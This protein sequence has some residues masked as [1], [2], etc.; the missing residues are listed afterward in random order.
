MK[1]LLQTIIFLGCYGALHAQC[2]APA[3]QIELHANNIQ[4]RILNGGDLFSDFNKGQFIPNPTPGVISPST[5]YTAG[6]WMGGVDPGGNLKIAAVDYRGTGKTDYSA[7]PLSLEGTTDDITCYNWDR[8]F[9]VTGSEIASFLNALPLTTGQAVAQFPAVMG[10]PARGNST[11]AGIWGFD[12]P[13]TTQS[14]APFVDANGDGFYTPLAGDYPAVELRGMLPFVPA[15]IIWCV[16]NDQKGGANHP[17]TNGNP[18]QME[19]QLTTWAFNCPD[20]PVLNNTIFTSH[21]LINRSSENLDSFFVG[22]WVDFDLGCHMD[23]YVGCDPNRNTMYVYNQDAQDGN[24]GITCS[25]TPTF[26]TNPPVQSVTFLG[27]NSIQEN[28]LHSFVAYGIGGSITDDPTAPVEYYSNLTGH[29]LG[30]TPMTYGGTGSGGST[31]TK[32]LFPDDPANPNGWSMCTNNSAAG[33]RRVIGNRSVGLLQPGQVSELNT[34]W[35]VHF[36]TPPPCNLGNTLSEVD[37]LHQKHNNGYAGLCSSVSKT[38]LAP[39]DN[40]ELFPNPTA[41]DATLRYGAIKVEEIRVFDAAGKLVQL[42]QNV[43]PGET[44]LKTSQLPVGVYTLQV[45]T[46]EGI[47]AKK[48][49]LVR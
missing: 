32:H 46:A 11:F 25:G 38:T 14:L 23:D 26:T 28:N 12:L 33:D 19:V 44:M 49:T 1:K 22:L 9:R 17:V 45:L 5:I 48:L 16:F 37:V 2:P 40:V 10:W 3:S 15:E 34:A 47:L 13:F 39:A 7:G 8:H 4:A 18:I 6:L 42:L 31:P 41:A 43:E 29:W 36:N 20:E 35:T 30:G 24:P 21:K 27:D